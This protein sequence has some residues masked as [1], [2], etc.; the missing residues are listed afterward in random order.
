MENK[1]KWDLSFLLEG[2]DDTKINEKRELIREKHKEFSKKWKKDKSYLINADKLKESLD[3]YE[4][5]NRFYIRGGTEAYY[6]HLRSYQDQADERIKSKLNKTTDFLNELEDE[7]R[8]FELS[9][10]KISKEK[11]DEF[12]ENSLLKDYHH[13]LEKIFKESTHLLTEDEEKI[14]SL[15]SKVTYDNWENLTQEFLNKSEAEVLDEEGNKKK[16]NFSELRGFLSNNDNGFR[17][18]ISD[19]FE[20][21]VERYHE[22]AVIELNS[23]LENKKIDDNLRKFERADSAR[24]LSDDIDSS[25]VDVLIKSVSSRFSLAHR[26]Y[27]LK[28]D[29]L[30]IKKFQYNDRN[31]EIGS[32]DKKYSYE[33]SK[34][35]IK[36]VSGN[37]DKEFLDIF[38]RYLKNNQI[39]VFPRKGKRGGAC[40]THFLISQPTYILL[41]YND[42]LEDV[43]TLAH[44]LGHGINNELIKKNQNALNF[45]TP[46]STAEVASTFMEYFVLEELMKNSDDET[47]LNLMIAKLQNDIQT[48]FR[49]VACYMFEQELHKSFRE[50]GYISKKYIGELFEKYMMSY[51]GNTFEKSDSMKRGWVYWPHIRDFFYN[52][53][54]ASGLLIS[55]NLQRKVKENPRFINKVKKFLSAGT[56]KSPKEIFL[57]LDIDITK[58]EFWKEGL[59]EVEDLLNKTEELAR[60]LGKIN[61]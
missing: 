37:I 19:V 54:Y 35:L 46:K 52:Y 17:K 39:D 47:K 51:L 11:Q 33:E 9:L 60:K 6:F 36:K 5:L 21:I 14:M 4:I 10:A 61:E 50:Q 41:N 57:D 44:E 58:E 15:K 53:S 59:E 2:D 29:I 28:G 13:Y 26:F 16:M 24:H 42:K 25:I 49:Q 20:N 27:K 32:L 48:I 34:V 23:L 43:T 3:N 18:R 30:G 12:L 45:G 8:F 56:S 1:N 31:I 7:I 40:C 22:I 55:K 38:K